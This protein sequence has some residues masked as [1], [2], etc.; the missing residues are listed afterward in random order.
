MIKKCIAGILCC[1]MIVSLSACSREKLD[2]AYNGLSSALDSVESGLAEGKETAKQAVDALRE[3]GVDF[4]ALQSA[5]ESIKTQAD[6]QIDEMG[7]RPYFD[8]LGKEMTEI[9][10]CYEKMRSA[11]EVPISY[12]ETPAANLGRAL[13]KTGVIM[14]FA[15]ITIEDNKPAKMYIFNYEKDGSTGGE[16]GRTTEINLTDFNVADAINTKCMI[17]EN[18]GTA[19][20][21]D[22]LLK[23][24]RDIA[25]ADAEDVRKNKQAFNN[26]NGLINL[27]SEDTGYVNSTFD[28]AV[29]GEKYK[30]NTFRAASGTFYTYVFKDNRLSYVITEEL[31]QWGVFIIS[32]LEYGSSADT[33][34]T[35]LT[36]Y[37]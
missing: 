18:G 28:A 12:G 24:K 30:M 13:H 26:A 8:A 11:S 37:K 5:V 16:Y 36:V 10:A 9:E 4:D 31:G 1:A 27:V 6:A 7:A 34:K 23:T 22:T 2:D 25:S 32:N 17:R 14:D 33:S 29:S 20:I 19:Y 35:D 3:N 21:C 15:Y